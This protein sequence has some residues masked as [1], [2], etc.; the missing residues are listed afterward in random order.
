[1]SIYEPISA[2]ILGHK[3]FIGSNQIETDC[4]RCVQHVNFQKNRLLQYGHITNSELGGGGA[5]WSRGLIPAPCPGGPRFESRRRRII[6][7]FPLSF[8][9]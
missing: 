9:K 2:E 4:F 3:V 6:F 5:R 7:R 1:M 8:K